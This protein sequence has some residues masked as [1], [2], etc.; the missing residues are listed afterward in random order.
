MRNT[1]SPGSRAIPAGKRP[2]GEA[3]VIGAGIS[4]LLAGR[5][6]ARHF[7]RV[8]ILDR[9]GSPD[10]AQEARFRKGVPQGRH[11]H[12]LATRGSELLE[13]FFPGLDAELE[14]A[15]APGLD[16]TADTVTEMSSGRMPRFES[17][18]T[19]RA[20][21]RPLLEAVI[22]ERLRREPAV[23]FLSDVEATGLLLEDRATRGVSTRMRGDRRGEEGEV[24]AE[25]VVDASGQSSRA[26]RWLSELGYGVPE[27]TVVDAGLGYA[28]RW[29]RVPEGFGEN[30]EDW[31]S[32][33]VLPEW[34]DNPRG[35]TL[36][37][38]EGG[39]W[40]AVLT[41]SGG[42]HPPT[43]P[44]RFEEFA[45]SLPSPIIHEAISVA[46][47][48]SPV[49]GYRRTANRRLHYEKMSLPAGFL[50]TG[51]AATTLNPSYG[52]G[53]TAAALSANVLEDC[54]AGSGFSRPGSR[55]GRRFHGRQV[56][57]VSPC[58]TTTTSNDSQWAASGLEDLNAPRRLA[59]G[60]SEQVMA[61]ATESP[62]VV[63][64]MF[65][66]KNVL[67]SPAAMLRPGILAPA[68]WRTFSG[69]PG[70]AKRPAIG[71]RQSLDGG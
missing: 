12:S 1:R 13:H 15:G 66:V 18:I 39:L 5:V 22:R 7:G 3:L 64:T 2:D 41:G 47:P 20:A 14:A 43:D 11:L 36:R 27:K 63:K 62:A 65:E 16:Q 29:Y 52:T 21:S 19:M 51:D 17:G 32:L 42:D 54:L 71:R 60:V 70:P 48:V 56:K 24:R 46:E 8:T 49:Y 50:V 38:V 57:A 69:L 31:L 4:G 34:P 58:W 30:G 61:L 59:H 67:R 6:L 53:M 23:C 9:D 28:S 55:F 26:P 33:A 35:G 25:L 37:Q 45:A 40:T 44:A 10:D 68:L